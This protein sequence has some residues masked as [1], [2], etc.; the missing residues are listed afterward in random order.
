MKWAMAG[1]SR[2]ETRRKRAW[3]EKRPSIF[4]SATVPTPTTKTRR[5][6]SFTK[7]GSK[8][9]LALDSHRHGASRRVAFNWSDEF[10][11]QPSTNL[12]VR[13][14]R[15]KSPQILSGYA[16]LVEFAQ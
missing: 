15:E 8:L 4:P 2:G 11:G 1:V 9:M 6:R 14:A 10:P 3:A 7:M 13:V 5:S 12:L 16:L